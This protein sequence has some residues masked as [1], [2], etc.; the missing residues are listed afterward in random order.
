MYTA[1]ANE[2]KKVLRIQSNGLLKSTDMRMYIYILCIIQELTLSVVLPGKQHIENV[3]TSTFYLFSR[4]Y[5][6]LDDDKLP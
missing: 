3:D 2:K 5:N 1:S 4:R 6:G